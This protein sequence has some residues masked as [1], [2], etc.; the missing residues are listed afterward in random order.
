MF[1]FIFQVLDNGS[2]LRGGQVVAN[3]H[4]CL[5]FHIPVLKNFPENLNGKNSTDSEASASRAPSDLSLS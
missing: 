2:R 3:E 4:A 1:S 5:I